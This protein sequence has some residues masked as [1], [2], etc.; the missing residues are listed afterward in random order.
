MRKDAGSS[1]AKQ[2]CL[3]SCQVSETCYNQDTLIDET[4][5]VT[6]CASVCHYTAI[7]AGLVDRWKRTCYT[8]SHTR[9]AERRLCRLLEM[10]KKEEHTMTKVCD[11]CGWEYNEEEG[12]PDGGIEPGTK[13]EDLPDDFVCSLCGAGK[14]EFSDAD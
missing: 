9:A 4:G 11:L 14:D 1:V 2:G 5:V 7:R 6:A 8:F 13:W 3:F 12:Y 10:I